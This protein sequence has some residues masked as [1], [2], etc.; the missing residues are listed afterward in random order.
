MQDGSTPLIYYIYDISVSCLIKY[1]F[2]LCDRMNGLIKELFY[3]FIK[4]FLLLRLD[5]LELGVQNPECRIHTFSF[6]L[7]T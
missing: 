3:I 1:H 5:H 2:S 4:I 7:S 6:S